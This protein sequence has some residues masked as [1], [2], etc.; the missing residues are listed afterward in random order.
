MKNSSTAQ[1]FGLLAL[2]AIIGCT[3]PGPLTEYRPVVDRERTNMAQ[4]ESDLD[5]CRTIA[6]QV[7]ANYSKRHNKQ[8][9]T[10]I[11]GGLLG[12]AIGG[13]IFGIVINDPMSIVGGAIYGGISGAT[14]ESDYTHDLLEFG[15]QRIVDRCMT[16]RGHTILNDIGRG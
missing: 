13:L 3:G 6:M 12:G 5:T 1:I 2:I 7:E 14:K 10:N 11:I 15:P 16:E 9:T 4:F 8:M